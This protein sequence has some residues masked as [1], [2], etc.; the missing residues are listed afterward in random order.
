MLPSLPT[1]LGKHKR[2]I[3]LNWTRRVLPCGVVPRIKWERRDS[4]GMWPWLA[5]GS[6][7]L[8]PVYLT[9]HYHGL[10]CGS[11]QCVHDNTWFV[12]PLKAKTWVLIYY[13]VPI[14]LHSCNPN[15]LIPFINDEGFHF[16]FLFL[17]HPLPCLI[18]IIYSS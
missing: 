17:H 16:F 1:H 7:L 14:C 5:Y 6:Q 10:C 9:H 4:E 2:F 8:V 3:N 12:L 13:H 18:I 11:Q 15:L